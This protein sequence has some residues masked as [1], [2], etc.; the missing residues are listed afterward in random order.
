MIYKKKFLTSKTKASIKT[1]MATR[2]R[3]QKTLKVTL[4]P[5]QEVF[6]STVVREVLGVEKERLRKW[7]NGRFVTPGI[8]LSPGPGT[9]NLFSK[10]DLYSIALFKHL[11]DFGLNRRISSEFLNHLSD[12]GDWKTVIGGSWRF[13]VVIHNMGSQTG[14]P[15]VVLTDKPP[16]LHRV[17]GNISLVIDLLQISRDVDSA[18]RGLTG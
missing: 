10:S 18:I 6:E 3:K 1:L 17:E 9:S 5:G 7:V 15:A 8:L 16:S 14:E 12:Y 2:K 11:V 4:A 13:M